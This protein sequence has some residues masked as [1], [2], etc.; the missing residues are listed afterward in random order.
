M[1]KIFEFQLKSGE[2]TE[3]VDTKLAWSKQN[4]FQSKNHTC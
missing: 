1:Y 3:F 4:N 2:H